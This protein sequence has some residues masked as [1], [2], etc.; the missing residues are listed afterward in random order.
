ML[1]PDMPHLFFKK[2]WH[3]WKKKTKKGKKN[4]FPQFIG[5]WPN[6]VPSLPLSSC[7]N[8][9]FPSFPPYY[10]IFQ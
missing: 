2:M 9:D 7:L 6:T 10:F 1:F 8:C 5:Y 3:V 4:T